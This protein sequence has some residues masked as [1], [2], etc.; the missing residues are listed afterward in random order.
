VR[1]DLGVRVDYWSTLSRI[2]VGVDPRARLAIDLSDA[3]TIH[4]AAGLAHQPAVFL[5]PLPGL[6]D[7]ALSRGLSR[8]F[9]SEAGGEIRLSEATRLKIQG[10][11]HTYDGLLLPELVQD[12]AIRDNTP[13][14]TAEAY[15]L[16]VFL[17]RDISER[18]SGWVSYTY[19]FATADSGPDVVGEFKPDFD[20]RHV[21]NVVLL[22]RVW[23]GLTLG[24][25]GQVRSG[26]VVEQ[27]N[28]RYTQRLP[29]F[30][31]A[32]VRVQYGWSGRLAEMKVYAEILNASLQREYLD[33]D[34]LLGQCIAS[35]APLVTIPNIGVRADF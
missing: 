25:R 19:G 34:C 11:Y 28:R 1:A 3:F 14:A 5:L 30:A 24:A 31:R 2:V 35:Q 8:S 7:V 22:W 21:L 6:T 33:A 9:Q 20:V 13:L 10:Y 23:R 32:D 4:A 27:L 12:A 15:G 26:R 18:V 29:W 17:D 16:E